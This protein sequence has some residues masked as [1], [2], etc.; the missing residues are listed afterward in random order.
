MRHRNHRNHDNPCQ[1][2]AS[3]ATWLGY[4]GWI[5]QDNNGPIVPCPVCNDDGAMERK[6]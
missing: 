5:E 2:C 1:H 4:P 3:D 6:D